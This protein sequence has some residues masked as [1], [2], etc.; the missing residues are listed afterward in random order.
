MQHEFSLINSRPAIKNSVFK[1]DASNGKLCAVNIVLS[2]NVITSSTIL[3]K[4]GAPITSSLSMPVKEVIN[5]GM[6][7][8]GLI[9]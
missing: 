4:I 5:G 9:R 2:I 6:Y 1:N 7:V 3:E 8:C